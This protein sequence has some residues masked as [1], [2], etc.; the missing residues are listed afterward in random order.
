MTE[1]FLSPKSWRAALDIFVTK[2]HSVDKRLAGQE[3]LDTYELREQSIERDFLFDEKALLEYLLNVHKDDSVI[4]RIHTWLTDLNS[5][6]TSTSSSNTIKVI[7]QKHISRKEKVEHYFQLVIKNKNECKIQFVPLNCRDSASYQLELEARTNVDENKTDDDDVSRVE[8]G[9]DHVIVIRLSPGCGPRQRD[10]VR[11]RLVPRLLGWAQSGH[12]AQTQVASV[13]LVGLEAYSREYIRL[14]NKYATDIVS[15]W[16]ESSDPE[17]FVHED[18]GIAAY[19]LLLWSQQ[20][21]REQ[22]AEDR[23][24]SFV[25]LGC[26]NGLLVYILTMEGHS[27]V[28]YDIR[29]R[30]I[31]AWY[32]DTVRLEEKTIVPSLD[33]RFPGVDW[34]LGNHSDELTPWIPVLAALSGER[35]SFWVLPCCPFS[36]SAKYQRKTALKSVWRDY[37]DWILNISHEMGFDIKEDRM[38]IPSTKRVCLVGHHQRPINLEQL[39]ILVKS[40]K[41][42]FVPRQKI[43]KVRNC[44]K[45]DK[46]FTVSIVDKVVEWCLWEK[47]VVEVNQVQWNSGCVLPLGDIVKKLQ[48]NGVDMSQLKQECGGLQTLFRNHH[49]IFVVEKGCVRLRIPGRDIKRS[50]KETT[51]DRLKTKPCWH[52]T[53]HPDGCPLSEELC[54]WIH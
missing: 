53:N 8:A 12:T 45:L 48:E 4:E 36:F 37:L 1:T 34:I 6:D 28:G 39:E 32:P 27:G 13:S 40:D 44:T 21:E 10:W 19:I 29:R 51:S 43:E 3:R 35:T 31:W 47:N 42:T 9:A 17:K 50:S 22:W 5:S 25:D 30:G 49:Y 46:H 7:L 24:Q 52:F 2:P 54:S 20:R 26:G 33:T 41:K 15:N 14:K 11:G 23:R 18:I 16:A 38:K